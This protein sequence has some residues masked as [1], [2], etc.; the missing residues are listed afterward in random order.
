MRTAAIWVFGLVS[1]FF[2]GGFAGMALVGT[3]TFLMARGNGHFWGALAGVCL[4]ACLR[5]WF[6]E[7]TGHR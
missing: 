1:F 4:F 2:F 6:E 5:L 3:Q 7:K